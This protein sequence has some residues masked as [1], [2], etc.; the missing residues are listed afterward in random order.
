MSINKILKISIMIL[1]AFVFTDIALSCPDNTA[2]TIITPEDGDVVRVGSTVL[3]QATGDAVITWSGGSFSPS[4]GP[5]V[6]WTVPGTPGI[7]TIT[8]TNSYGSDQVK[9]KAADIIYV[10]LDADPGGEGTSWDDA[11]D[12]LQEG[13]NDASAGNHIWVAEGIY[14]PGTSHYDT[15]QLEEGVEVYGGFD[16][17]ETARSQRDWV[18]HETILSGDIDD[19]ETLNSTNCHHVVTCQNSDS[20][21]VLDGFTITMGWAHSVLCDGAGMKIVS[22]HP[23]VSNCT[24]RENKADTG[25]GDGGGMSCL[26]SSPTVTNCIFI[27]NVAGDDGG[28]LV[29]SKGSNGT[30]T[31][32]V[33]YS[34]NTNGEN[35]E[36]DE[37]EWKG[38][39][40]G[41][42]IWNTRGEN[43]NQAGSSP[44]FINCLIAENSTVPGVYG[45]KRG[46]GVANKGVDTEP[47]FINCT[48]TEN[49]AYKDG[50]GM[51]TKDD[52][53]ATVINCIFWDNEIGVGES[54][55][56][57]H[58]R[59]GGVTNVSYS[60]LDQ[61]GYD[62]PEDKNISQVPN[63]VDTGD[64]DGP[65]NRFL[66]CDDG[67]RIRFDSKCVDAGNGTA[68]NAPDTDILGLERVDV[69]AV[70]N[71]GLGTPYSDMGAYEAVVGY[72][73]F[74]SV[75]GCG[76]HEDYLESMIADEVVPKMK[77]YFIVNG[78]W[79]TNAR[80]EFTFTRTIPG[81]TSMVTGRPVQKPYTS[82]E[83]PNTTTHHGWE[84]N[85]GYSGDRSGWMLHGYYLYDEDPPEDPCYTGNE[86][87]DPTFHTLYIASV[88]D[89]VH[90][91]GL[92]TAMY[93]NKLKFSLFDRSYNA[94]NGRVGETPEDKLD[95]YT[96]D[97][98]WNT[99]TLITRL[100]T[101]GLDNFVFF[102]F[103]GPDSWGHYIYGEGWGGTEWRAAVVNVDTHLETIFNMVKGLSNKDKPWYYN[104][105][106]IMTAD[107][108][109]IDKNHGDYP[110]DR[111][112]C[113]LPFG[114]W[115]HLI[116]K[117]V[118]P[119]DYCDSSREDP[120][121]GRG[122]IY[123][124]TYTDQPIRHAD[125][126]D[127]ALNL[128]GLPA[129]DGALIKGMK[130][131]SP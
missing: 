54:D 55:V 102:H 94:T 65:D 93:A 112:E 106:V 34:N 71:T 70:T 2:P 125:G 58:N 9:V 27:D 20:T 77:N 80:A 18:S 126:V 90:D 7:V 74:I 41:G 107:H 26:Y 31:N 11:F 72:T 66:T 10:D 98:G 14:K 103:R 53:V 87:N 127:L 8:A 101:R 13:F 122:D 44:K 109:G 104:T 50:G 113:Q 97:D 83:W 62:D 43:D 47:V 25:D 120:G 79:T 35:T 23:T 24:F 45:G 57:I 37:G 61:S 60:D 49:I 6:Y 63:F 56:A 42:A 21:A 105:A 117:G 28:A 69:R 118:D 121:T 5:N 15:F 115:G 100:T 124:T 95:Y 30:F 114:V 32:C 123:N 4:T 64:H 116:P 33:F 73:I 3:C 111:K 1:F 19:D 38:K 96:D 36:Y 92:S 16:G 76:S 89:V 119:Y 130:L 78:M 129:I 22:A 51:C 110:A 12:T 82:P 108:G 99:N 88:F 84:Y 81:H 128:M 91:N 59:K 75:D 68:T 39:S 29:N 17:T 85:S 48:F 40:N 46:G 67:W 131:K 52:A 86:N